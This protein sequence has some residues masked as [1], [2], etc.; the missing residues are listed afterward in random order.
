MTETGRAS[1]TMLRPGQELKFDR[2]LKNTSIESRRSSTLKT[3]QLTLEGKK[4]CA[5]NKTLL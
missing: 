4:V 1:K 3:L 2:M 5:E